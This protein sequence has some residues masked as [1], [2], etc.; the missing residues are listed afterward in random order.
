MKTQLERARVGEI[1]P[2]MEEAARYDD[3]C[4]E[5]IR[6]G[7]AKGNIVLYGNPH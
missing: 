1:T 3:V 2:Q 4:P 6:E 5:F 7:V